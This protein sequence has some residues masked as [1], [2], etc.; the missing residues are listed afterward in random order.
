MNK[1]IFERTHC[2][3]CDSDRLSTLFSA[4]RTS[5]SFLDFLKIE[6]FYSSQ[7]WEEYHKGILNELVFKIVQCDDCGFTFQR[8]V[9]NETGMNLLYNNWLDQDL[10]KK[11]YSEKTSSRF[12]EILLNILGRVNR[13]QKELKIL[14][15]GAGYGGFCKLS[16]KFGYSTY[17]YELSSDKDN[18][19]SSEMGITTINNL[20]NYHS[21]FDFIYLNQ[22]L[23]HLLDPR[24]VLTTLANCLRDKGFIFVSV[25]NCNHIVGTINKLALS[26]EL[27]SQ[28]SP[29][30]HI[31]AFNNTTLKR[32]GT[33][34]GLQTFG[35]I[36][37]G[38][39]VNTKFLPDE[40]LFLLKSYLK[41]FNGTSLFF[42][43]HSDFK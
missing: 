17:A 11:Y 28:L 29:F 36:E 12:A 4:E 30:Q 22:V 6:R 20:D 26:K 39:L 24:E 14:D 31:N 38:K 35:L 23:E 1:L 25:P 34:S 43:K 15:Y 16:R 7:F 5:K 40:M 18:Y 21:F 37:F 8:E 9:L 19:L 42:I 41:S 27:F 3:I 13:N 33:T 32:I 2:P 10:L